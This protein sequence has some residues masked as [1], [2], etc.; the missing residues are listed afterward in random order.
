VP[1]RRAVREVFLSHSS[2]DRRFVQRLAQFLDS[3]KIHYWYSKK[4]IPGA[5]RWHDEIGR[6]LGRCDWFIVVLS[7]SSVDS[8]WVTHELLYALGQERLKYRIIP[9]LFEDCNQRRLSWTLGAMQMVDFRGSFEEGFA[10]LLRV[11]GIKPKQSK[12]KN[13]AKR[14]KTPGK[15]TKN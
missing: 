15:E 11:W 3:K 13:R 4:H 9:V 7:K 1:R 10:S 6:A 8:L 5:A 12:R 14:L 2:V